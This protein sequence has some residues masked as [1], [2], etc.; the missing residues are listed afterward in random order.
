MVRKAPKTTSGTGSDPRRGFTLFEVL[1][2]LA[3]I[4][5]FTGFFVLRFNDGAT[6]EALAKG[7]TDLRSA[8]LKAKKRAYAF[9]RDQYLIF[10]P[11]GFEI[12]ETPPLP[13]EA[14]SLFAPE[15]NE[16]SYR[17]SFRFPEGIA[18]EWMAAGDKRWSHQP[19][20]YWTFRAS[21]LSDPLTVRLT[22][23]R[24]YTRL[25]FNALTGLA[26]EETFIE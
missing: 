20:F 22:R 17:E 16:R 13:D 3:I 18:A 26:E 5:L 9:R 10:S 6:E 7:S 4:A 25:S 12:T 24:S 11:G 14:K 1:I 19:G 23:G 21:G 15:P 2:V 8:A